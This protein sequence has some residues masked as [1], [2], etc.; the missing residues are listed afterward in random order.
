[1]RPAEEDGVR[2]VVKV[3]LGSG[4]LVEC[5]LES[6]LGPVRLTHVHVVHVAG[7]EQS[8]HGIGW[9]FVGH[10]LDHGRSM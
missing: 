10:K 9:M 2:V 5:Q 1:M 6:V 4:E 3:S 7:D 8:G